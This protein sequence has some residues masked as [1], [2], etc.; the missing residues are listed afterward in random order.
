MSPGIRPE[1]VPPAPPGSRVIHAL[2]VASSHY[3][4]HLATFDHPNDGPSGPY[5]QGL[6]AVRGAPGCDDCRRFWVSYARY[7][8]TEFLGAPNV[9]GMAATRLRKSF[10]HLSPP[11]SGARRQAA[12]VGNG[13]GPRAAGGRRRNRESGFGPKTRQETLRRGAV[14]DHCG[15][16]GAAENHGRSC[17]GKTEPRAAGCWDRKSERREGASLCGREAPSRDCRAKVY[18]PPGRR[19]PENGPCAKGLGTPVSGRGRPDRGAGGRR[20]VKGVR[21]SG[22]GD[23]AAGGRWRDAG[24]G[25][26]GSGFGL[27]PPATMQQW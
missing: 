1:I 12:G 18:P 7:C 24:C 10:A 9:V 3:I 27:A 11:G 20:R 16:H 6:K 26:P 15:G 13:T 23:R 14:F 4:P 22:I 21:V 2:A 25:Q 5:C 19:R 17:F 8:G